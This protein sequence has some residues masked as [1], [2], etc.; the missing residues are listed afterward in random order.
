[1]DG[2]MDGTC[3]VIPPVSARGRHLGALGCQIRCAE[4]RQRSGVS[5]APRLLNRCG[6]GNAVARGSGHCWTLGGDACTKPGVLNAL[7][8]FKLTSC[9]GDVGGSPR[10][11]QLG[12]FHPFFGGDFLCGWE[13]GMREKPRRI[14]QHGAMEPRIAG[15]VSRATD[16][17][18]S[19]QGTGQAC[20]C[21]N[22]TLTFP[23]PI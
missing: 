8:S 13:E 12:F 11:G 10:R 17:P 9:S 19:P 1:M 5:V 18:D 2:W 20:H 6:C 7:L 22:G 4:V 21:L 23:G 16:T 3:S 15:S 14:P